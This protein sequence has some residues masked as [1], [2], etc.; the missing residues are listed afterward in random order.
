VA[1]KIEDLSEADAR[2]I[3]AMRS[4]VR[5]HYDPEARDRYDDLEGK[6]RLLDTI[7]KG[8]WIEPS[9]TLKL[10]CLGIT[11]GD[12]LVQKMGVTWVAVE[13]EYGRDPALRDPGKTTVIFPMT[14]ISKRIEKGESVDVRTLFEDACGTIARLRQAADD[15]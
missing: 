10:Q 11:L 1:Q 15:A 2:R 9:E 4:W 8:G 7:I 3:E 5:E 13:D 14:S 6:L 12:A